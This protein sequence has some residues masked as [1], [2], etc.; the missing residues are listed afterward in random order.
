MDAILADMNTQTD[1]D[2]DSDVTTA[3]PNAVENGKLG[4]YDRPA[5]R[6][7]SPVM[8]I[9]LVVLALI[10]AYLLWQFIF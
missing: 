6:G 2:L 4:V 1:H 5:R 9:I 8:M 7:M 3:E 10:A